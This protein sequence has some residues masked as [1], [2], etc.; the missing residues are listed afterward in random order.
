MVLSLLGASAGCSSGTAVDGTILE[1]SFRQ[2][3]GETAEAVEEFVLDSDGSDKLGLRVAWT[4]T[5]ESGPGEHPFG[6]VNV[7]VERNDIGA[8]AVMCRTDE[9]SLDALLDGSRV[10]RLPLSCEYSAKGRSGSEISAS[11][12]ANGLLTRR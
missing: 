9:P 4:F 2:I 5:T 8:T 10:W 12:W 3:D 11:L 1:Q 6:V 7:A